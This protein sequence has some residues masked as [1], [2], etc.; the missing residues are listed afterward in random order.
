M[1]TK[2]YSINDDHFEGFIE[3]KLLGY[4]ERL[5]L[6]AKL[7]AVYSG[8]E[9]SEHSFEVMARQVEIFCESVT[10]CEVKHKPTGQVFNSVMEL[11]IYNEGALLIN[12]LS[13]EFLKGETLGKP[14][15]NA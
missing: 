9:V 12:T 13:A 14:Q 7:R 1:K 11:G 5:R 15:E 2:R 6:I 3:T 8:E 10:A 4:P